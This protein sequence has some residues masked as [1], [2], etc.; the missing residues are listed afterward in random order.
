MKCTKAFTRPKK[1]GACT[2]ALL[3]G[4]WLFSTSSL[5]TVNDATVEKLIRQVEAL[6][7]RVQELEAADKTLHDDTVALKEAI[8]SA[9]TSTT[10]TS[11]Q[12]AWAKK[13]K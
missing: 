1:F 5:A 7:Q 3:A 9:T 2:V 8:R 6:T 4:T 12:L 13:L 11:D 10:K